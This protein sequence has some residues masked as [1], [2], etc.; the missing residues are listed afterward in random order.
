[1]HFDDVLRQ[2][3]TRRGLLKV[4]AAGALASQVAWVPERMAFAATTLPDIQFDIGNFI[5]PAFTVNGVQVRFGPVYT[6]FVP[7]KLTRNPTRTDQ[8]TLAGALNTIEANL[9]FSPSGVFTFVAYGLPYFRRLPST[10][11][12]SRI[13][14]LRSNTSRSVLEEAVPSPTDV[15]PGNGITK[16]TYN[17]PVRIE[18][19]DLL[20]TLRSDSLNNLGTVLGFLES[21]L[22]FLSFQTARLMFQQIG[23]TRQVAN[24]VGLPYRTRINPQ[25][26]MWM[27]FADQQT[28]AAGP[29]QIVTFVGNASAHL[30]TAFA[31]TYFDNGSIQHLSHV[32]QDLAQFYATP[33]QDPPAGETYQERLQYMFRSNQR[34]TRD[35][36]ISDG[37]A[38]QFT[39]GGGPSFLPNTFQGTGDAL[40]NINVNGTVFNPATGAGTFQG[41]HRMGHIAALQ[42]SSRA[43]DGTPVHIRMD[44]AGYDNMDV[45]D[46]S[47]QPKLQFTAFVPTAEFF[48]AMR[49]NTAALDI[50]AATGNLVADDDN[51]LERFIMAT[52][53]QNFLVPP[54]RH[55]AFPLLELV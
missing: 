46:G 8:A 15:V 22:P 17:V 19:N 29:A 25:S 14:R 32:I 30:T 2:S 45:P 16:E 40:A 53:R 9:P 24:A 47:N 23:I 44:G 52:R 28:N 12:S 49:A 37:N 26:P 31:G 3:F 27:G 38:D 20:F 5:P 33:Q 50:I 42:R 13:P 18:N 54:R 35:G 48:R 1:M 55:R 4:G 11:V 7:A 36:L 6:L 34:G 21:R 39:D 41:Q 43:A 10:L 51:G